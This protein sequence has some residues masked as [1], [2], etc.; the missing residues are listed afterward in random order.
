[1]LLADHFKRNSDFWLK[2][3]VELYGEDLSKLERS[4]INRLASEVERFCQNYSGQSEF[5]IPVA[6]VR[7]HLKKLHDQLGEMFKSLIPVPSRLWTKPRGRIG[8]VTWHLPSAQ[9]SIHL[10]RIHRLNVTRPDKPKLDMRNL[11]WPEQE[12]LKGQA[13]WEKEAMSFTDGAISRVYTAQWPHIFWLATS[14]IL[15]EGGHRLWRCINCE[16]LFIKR[17]RQAY[18]SPRC[19]QKVRSERWYRGHMDEAR[20]KQREARKQKKRNETGSRT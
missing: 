4:D 13:K 19:S 14:E 20:R 1:M 7:K 16:R 8:L 6:L 11:S 12:V 9:M 18:C 17:K 2:W 15:V 5:Q 3:L 10:Y